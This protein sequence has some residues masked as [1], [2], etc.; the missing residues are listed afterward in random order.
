MRG[1]RSSNLSFRLAL[2]SLASA[3]AVAVVCVVG[4]VSLRNISSVTSEAV[5]RQIVA[6]DESRAFE[7][8]LYQKGFLAQ[9]MLSGDRTWL[10]Q[11]DARRAAFESW[12][13]SA[14]GQAPAGTRNELVRRI[15]S[16]Y[17]NYDVTRRRALQRFDGGERREALALLAEAQART[18]E[19]LA[20]IQAFGELRRRQAEETLAV[21]EEA[22]QRLAGFLVA[23]SVLAAVA[24]IAAG[25]LWA[26]RFARPIYELRLRAES[27]A[28][29]TRLQVEAG[30]GDLDG[31]AAH[32]TALLARLEEMDGTLMEQR[33]RLAQ[34]EKLSEIG[35]LAAKLAHELLNPMAGMKAATQLLA[36]AASAGTVDGHEV[37]D[38]AGALDAEIS[39]VEQLVRRLVDYARPLSPRFEACEPGKLVT[40]ALEVSRRELDRAGVTVRQN[41]EPGLPP[42]EADPLLVTQALSNIIC[43][44]AQAA[45]AGTS[46]DID[47]RRSVEAGELVVFEVADRGAG[48]AAETLT[49]LFR[50]FFT[51]KPSGHGLGLAV[52]HHIIVE[53]GGRIT[54]HNRSGGGARFQV[55]IP[56]VR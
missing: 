34:N 55:A 26:R 37:R 39:R 17:V 51:T 6:L 28:H 13:A 24:S 52:S 11:V 16:E 7:S 33:R 8:L 38:T 45:A 30:R 23:A 12:L 46:I 29:R 14:E 27:V 9:Y 42:L 35:E 48:L 43:N 54:A 10:A 44:A 19:L 31:L 2:A 41:V 5:G 56:V 15:K 22:T 49:R 1:R 36:R 18:E 4:L 32:V 50:P 21:A 20:S 40:S 47:V 25:F 3:L 53:H